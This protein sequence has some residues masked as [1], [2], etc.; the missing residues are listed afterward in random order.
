MFS[1]QKKNFNFDGYSY[2]YYDLRKK[3]HKMSRR[4]TAG[5]SIMILYVIDYQGWIEVGFFIK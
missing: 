3:K 1:D 4:H 2:Y 5:G